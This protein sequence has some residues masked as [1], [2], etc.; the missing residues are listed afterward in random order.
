MPMF[1]KYFHSIKNRDLYK[2]VWKREKK[3]KKNRSA[4]FRKLFYSYVVMI[5][6]IFVLMIVILTVKDYTGE[7]QRI[8]RKAAI[9]AEQVSLILDDRISAIKTVVNR[10]NTSTTIRSLYLN[11]LENQQ[12]QDAYTLENIMTELKM[13]Q[14]EAEQ[15]GIEEIVVFINGYEKAY[16]GHGIIT[17]QDPFVYRPNTPELSFNNIETIADISNRKFTLIKDTLIYCDSYTYGSGS[18]KGLICV[19]MNL[20]EFRKDLQEAADGFAFRVLLNGEEVLASGDSTG[21]VFPVNSKMIEDLSCEVLPDMSVGIIFQG[22][23]PHIILLCV[24]PFACFLFFSWN[25]AKKHYEPIK[26]IK[27]LIISEDEIST[28]NEKERDEMNRVI[29][30]IKDLIVERNGYRERMINIRP[31]AQNGMLHGV[32]NESVEKNVLKVLSEEEYLDMKK[33]FFSVAA[34]NVFVSEQKTTLESEEFISRVFNKIPETFSTET[35]KIVSYRKDENNFYLIAN[36]DT[37]KEAEEIFYTI[38]SHMK[39]SLKSP[40]YIITFGVDEVKEDFSL[41]G[42]AYEHAKSALK[43]MLLYGRGEIYFYEEKVEPSVSEERYYFPKNSVMRLAK[44]IREKKTEEIREFLHEIYLKNREMGSRVNISVRMLIDEIH[45]TV[46]KSLREVNE[47]STFHISLECV[48]ETATLQEAVSYYVAA[49]EAVVGRM[50]EEEKSL[51]EPMLDEQISDFIRNNCFNSEISLK[52]I[53]DRF[54][55]SNKYISIVCK[56]YFGTTYLQ[57]IHKKRIERAIDLL[58]TTDKPIEVIAQEIGYT[59]PLTFRR[60]F[61]QVT[62]VNPSIYREETKD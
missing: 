17:F 33:P 2:I 53:S 40:D 31:Y 6:I 50:E 12:I 4:I 56:K 51:N 38:Y 44:M 28:E 41:F 49:L 7:K 46:V 21:D 29:E 30:G 59:S 15:S 27:K 26:N 13:F 34:V 52:M 16:T 3:M 55:V 39:E 1:E 57:Y 32:F 23:S 61:Q 60:N 37:Y 47:L 9:A 25:Q 43:H 11:L 58:Q 54:Q 5:S 19:S 18:P 62:G 36:S 35:T 24:I 14:I 42:E 10:I 20:E 8:E 45:I 48:Q 22:I